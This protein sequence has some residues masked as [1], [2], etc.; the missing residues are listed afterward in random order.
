MTHPA[1]QQIRRTFYRPCRELPA[2]SKGAL[3]WGSSFSRP[4]RDH[5]QY[6]EPVHTGG[7]LLAGKDLWI[8]LGPVSETPPG[9]VRAGRTRPLPWDTSFLSRISRS[10]LPELC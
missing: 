8:S 9:R 7:M 10:I 5:G 6:H 3:C 4:H 2:M 1:C